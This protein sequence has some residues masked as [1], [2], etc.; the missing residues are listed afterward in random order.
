MAAVG[1]EQGLVDCL[2]AAWEVLEVA[3]VGPQ[4]LEGDPQ[5]KGAMHV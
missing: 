2:K 1:E 5:A 3:E 4:A